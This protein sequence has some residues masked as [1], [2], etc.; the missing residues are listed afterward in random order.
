MEDGQ[1]G[2]IINTFEL[3]SIGSLKFFEIVP[4]DSKNCFKVAVLN[5]EG[6]FLFILNRVQLGH[7]W[8]QNQYV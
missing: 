7:S 4:D 1:F 3:F 6:Q 5:F 8:A 2:P